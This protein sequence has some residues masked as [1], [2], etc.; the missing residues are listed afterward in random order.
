[1]IQQDD[2]N[3]TTLQKKSDTDNESELGSNFY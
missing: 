1:M 2:I 3:N